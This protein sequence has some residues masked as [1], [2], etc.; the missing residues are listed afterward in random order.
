MK[1]KKQYETEREGQIEFFNI[2]SIPIDEDNSILIDNT[3]GV[4]NGN[5][6]EFKK[7]I[8]NLNKVLFQAIKYLSKM[9]IKG[10]SVP[11]TIL[12]ISLNTTEIYLYKSE[13]YFDD[14]HK[15]YVGASSK[16][17]ENFVANNYSQKL[18]YSNSS[19]VIELR[20]ILK[21]KKTLQEKYMP[22]NIDENCIVGWAERYYNENPKASK[23]DFIGD[24]DG[25]AVKIKGEIREPKHFQYLIN[26]YTGATNEKFK[27]LMDC[28]NDKLSK[29]DLGAFYTPE[30]YAQKVIKLIKMAID[31]VPEGN[32]YI[33]LDR[34]AGTGN[35]ES[36]FEGV[37]DKNNEEILSHC[38]LSTYEYYEYKVLC[39]RLIDKVRFIIPPSENLVEYANGKVLNADALSEKYI[40]NKD[41]KKIIDNPKCTIIMYENPPYSDSSA[42]TFIEDNK[43]NKRAKTRRKDS[44]VLNEFKKE[45]KNFNG[46]EAVAREIS[47]L[48]IWSAF[49]YY[50]RQNTDSYIVYSPIKYY[51]NVHL[52]EKKFIHGY[53]FNRKHFHASD[54]VISCIL[55]ANE[56]EK[57]EKISLHTYDINDDKEVIYLKEHNIDIKQ[58]NKNISVFNDRRNFNTDIIMDTE[59]KISVVGSDGYEKTNWVYEKGRKP[60][61]NDNIIAYLVAKSFMLDAKHYNLIRTNFD[62]ALKNSYG[63]WLRTDNYMELLPLFVAKLFP[64]DEWYEKDVYF[65]TADGGEKFKKDKEFLK[66]CLIYTCLSNQNKCI[67][68]NGTDKRYYRNEL[69]LDN[70]TIA[71]KQLIKMALDT[72]EQELID[73]WNKILYEAKKTK[74][75]NPQFTYGVYQITKELNTMHKEGVGKNKKTIPDYVELNG[76]LDV[77]RKKIKLYYKSH[78][79]KMMFKYELLK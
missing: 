40:N 19:D 47:N 34:C 58:V 6:F 63:F 51:K 3:D 69:C 70:D 56:T 42:I 45:L 59:N 11:A 52:I 4:Y 64:R 10:E 27:Y 60:I 54:S 67:S 16:H 50:L 29:K 13:D 21:G 1:V 33:I 61:Y 38:V 32:D 74:N 20:K 41:L 30:L 24:D 31:R 5:I 17:N 55:W 79:S 14:I 48:F 49:K 57:K 68:F 26:P 72:E 44:F 28:L 46:Q 8:D 76:Y 73:L 62:T 43:L 37:K 65:T 75:Y 36:V 35:L 12:L 25:I 77:L 18:D 71:S 15:I 22:I 9:R 39:E 78:I 53:A 66:M 7:D 23:G 2:F